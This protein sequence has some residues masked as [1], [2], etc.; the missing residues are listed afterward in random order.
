MPNYIL[1]SWLYWFRYIFGYTV[2]NSL[3]IPMIDLVVSTFYIEHRL[4]CLKLYYD[5]NLG[6]HCIEDSEFAVFNHLY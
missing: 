1:N 5:N 3:D 6:H 4:F 2:H